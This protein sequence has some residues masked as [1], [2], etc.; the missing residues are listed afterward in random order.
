MPL[1]AAAQ[2]PRMSIKEASMK[3]S[4]PS[5]ASADASLIAQTDIRPRNAWL[6]LDLP[7]VWRC[8]EL[9]WFLVLR[10]MKVRYKQAALGAAWTL[11]QPLFAVMIFTLVFGVFARL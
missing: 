6:D 3:S 2:S 7:G 9:L 5:V 11:I 8:R 1:R 4:Q 10:D